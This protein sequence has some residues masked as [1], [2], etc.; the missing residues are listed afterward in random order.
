M[1]LNIGPVHL[2]QGSWARFRFFGWPAHKAN[3]RYMVVDLWSIVSIGR[4]KLS[5]SRTVEYPDEH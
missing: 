2:G 1:S 3:G 5:V 4:W